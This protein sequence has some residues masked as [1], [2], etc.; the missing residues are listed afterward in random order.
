MAQVQTRNKSST[1]LADD[2]VTGH[3]RY[4]IAHPE[5]QNANTKRFVLFSD[6]VEKQGYKIK[7]RV[8]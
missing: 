1:A 6:S 4:A 2:E 3:T 5:C 8:I 7:S